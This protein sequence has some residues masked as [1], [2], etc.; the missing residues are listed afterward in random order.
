MAPPWASPPAFPGH[1]TTGDAGNNTHPFP[2]L[3]KSG[4]SSH[5]SFGSPFMFPFPL[6]GAGICMTLYTRGAHAGPRVY[7]LHQTSNGT[8]QLNP[9]HLCRSLQ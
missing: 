3:L 7:S 5:R 2:S 6:P 1:G 4:L 9:F 8:L